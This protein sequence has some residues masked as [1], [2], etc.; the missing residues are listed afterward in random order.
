[1]LVKGLDSEF[2]YYKSILFFLFFIEENIETS[3][4]FFSYEFTTKSCGDRL[5]FI[6]L[7]SFLRRHSYP[8][9]INFNN[10]I[11]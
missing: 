9:S 3:T 11:K 1:M 4:L 5:F 8:N 7:M 2:S 10:K 6:P